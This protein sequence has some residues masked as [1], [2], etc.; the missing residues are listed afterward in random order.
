MYI[1]ILD[2]EVVALVGGGPEGGGNLTTRSRVHEINDHT[3]DEVYRA[4]RDIRVGI[5]VS[6]AREKTRGLRIVWRAKQIGLCA[7]SIA[8]GWRDANGIFLAIENMRT[9]VYI[10]SLIIIDSM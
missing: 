4:M 1:R 7:Q 5:L 2:D 10:S 9:A 8:G 6:L 3:Y